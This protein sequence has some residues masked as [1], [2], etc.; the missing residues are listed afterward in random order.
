MHMDKYK[1]LNTPSACQVN[2]TIFKK[3]FYE[4]ANLSVRDRTLFIDVIE[5]ITW[6]YSLKPDTINIETYT[7]SERD[8][9]EIEVISI[10]LN[11][12]KQLIRIA[13]II[14]RTIPYPM[15]LIFELDNK[16]CFYTAHQRINLNDSSRHTL[17]ELIHTDWMTSDNA[18]MLQLDL[19]QMRFT[20]YYVLYQDIVDTISLHN[21]KSIAPSITVNNGCAARELLA[22]IKGIDTEIDLL[23]SQLKKE[24]QFNRK[25]ELNI[26][27]KKM[28]QNRDKL[29]GG[30]RA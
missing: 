12:D 26:A 9:Q 23:R 11:Q 8:Y 28:D 25:M 6:L 27:I 29:T 10:E 13:E 16:F 5:K 4:N 30:D 1:F 20:N 3:L 2:N 24:T 17:E 19:K 22:Q 15:L 7:D 14:M 18:F 21:I